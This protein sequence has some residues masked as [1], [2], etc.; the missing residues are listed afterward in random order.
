MIAVLRMH[1][2]G[3]KVPLITQAVLESYKLGILGCLGIL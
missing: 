1:V 2:W 3:P